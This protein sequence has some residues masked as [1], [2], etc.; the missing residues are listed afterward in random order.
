MKTKFALTMAL[1]G[2]VMLVGCSDNDDDP[3]AQEPTSKA[4]AVHAVSRKALGC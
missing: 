4:R 2:S 3:V 1:A